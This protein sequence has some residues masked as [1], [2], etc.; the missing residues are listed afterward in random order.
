MDTSPAFVEEIDFNE[1]ILDKMDQ[2]REVS[3]NKNFGLSS[4]YS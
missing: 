4:R 1:I 3:L 2:K